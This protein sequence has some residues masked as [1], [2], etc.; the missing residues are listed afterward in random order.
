[1]E[2]LIVPL[3]VLAVMALLLIEKD[4]AG[5]IRI[6]RKAGILKEFWW[7]IRERK[8]WW[9]TPIVVIL[10]ILSVFIVVTEQSVVLPFIYAVF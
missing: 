7:F 6:S 8:I 4:P 5:G 10:G 3:I 2:G 1:M 9:M